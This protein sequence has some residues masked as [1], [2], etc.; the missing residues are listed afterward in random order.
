VRLGII[1]LSLGWCKPFLTVPSCDGRAT[2]ATGPGNPQVRHVRNAPKATEMLHRRKMT[3][4][5]IRRHR[6]SQRT[7][8]LFG[9][10]SRNITFRYRPAWNH[11]ECPVAG[12]NRLTR[13]RTRSIETARKLE[14]LFSTVSTLNG[15][16]PLSRPAAERTVS[17]GLS[18][19][20]RRYSTANR[21]SSRNPR[22]NATSFT[23]V[24]G[25]AFE[26]ASLAFASRKSRKY[27][28]GVVP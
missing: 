19:N 26:S 17:D 15:P 1:A 18:P 24:A 28:T 8:R 3:R 11:V 23:V 20:C 27:R 21:P 22:R 13:C 12:S 16:Q 10:F 4:C 6:T 14:N 2:I 5:F 25:S 7:R 9:R